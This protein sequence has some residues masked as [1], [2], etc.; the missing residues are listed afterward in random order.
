MTAAES[1]LESLLDLARALNVDASVIGHVGGSSLKVGHFIDLGCD[2]L[3]EKYFEALK[4]KM[5]EL[6]M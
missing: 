6:N 1:F 2:T 5:E 3:S 4:N